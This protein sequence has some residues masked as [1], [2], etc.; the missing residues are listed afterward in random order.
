MPPISP[1]VQNT[2]LYP[3]TITTIIK[4]F[5]IPLRSPPP[6][7]SN[8]SSARSKLIS[9]PNRSCITISRTWPNRQSPWSTNRFS[10]SEQ[11]TL[12]RLI[13]VSRIRDLTGVCLIRLDRILR[14]FRE[15]E[16]IRK[17]QGM[18]K[19][20]NIVN[21]IPRIL[22]EIATVVKEFQWLAT[23]KAPKL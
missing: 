2:M 7:S 21:E 1:H 23:Y 17:S 14:R 16:K 18:A 6:N 8:Q 13:C 10:R 15:I 11:A 9:S 3:K 12:C 22:I 20:R 19:S 4:I 5:I